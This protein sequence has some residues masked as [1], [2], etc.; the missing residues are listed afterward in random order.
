MEQLYPYDIVADKA[1]EITK[2]DTIY[3]GI[4]DKH[5][6]VFIR[7]NTKGSLSIQNFYELIDSQDIYKLSDTPTAAFTS[8]ELQA[9]SLK[10]EKYGKVF[11]R[12]VGTIGCSYGIRD[13]NK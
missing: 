9:L 11:L 13:S 12:K 2:S 5:F 1:K 7:E 6:E 3:R 10:W 4:F 8:E